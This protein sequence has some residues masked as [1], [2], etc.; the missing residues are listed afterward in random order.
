MNIITLNKFSLENLHRLIAT[1]I[2]LFTFVMYYYTVAPTVSFWDCGEYIACSYRMGI[3]HPPGAPLYLLIARIFTLIPM[4]KDI[5]LRVNMI[6]VISSSLTTVL[7]YLIIVHLYREIVG[8]L[9]S[10]NEWI[11]AIFSG[12]LGALTFAFTHSIW[13]NAVE[14]EVY[15]LSMFLMALMVWLILVWNAKSQEPGNERYLLFIAY[16]I[17]LSTGIHLLTILVLPFLALIFYF[18]RYNF[19]IQSFIIL[20]IVTTF[21]MLAIF[22]GL[23]VKVPQMAKLIGVFPIVFFFLVINGITIWAFISKKHLLTL[24]LFSILLISGGYSTYTY[25]IIRSSLNPKIDMNNPETLDK[26]ASYVNREQYG[27]HSII[28]RRAVWENSPNKNQ[29]RSPSDFFW[30]YQVNK[31]YIRYFLWQ[32]VGRSKN[33]IDWS[34]DQFFG[35]PLLLG[36]VGMWWHFRKSTTYALSVFTLFFITGLAI[37]LYLNQSEPQPRER[38]YSYIGSFFA[39]SIWI[40]L[41]FNALQNIL[42]PFFN[43]KN[44][45]YHT[46]FQS[47]LFSA[48]LM[49]APAQMLEK[50]IKNHSRRGNYF[51]WDFAYNTLMSC[52]PNGILFT[53]G[54][55]DTYPLWYLQEVEGIRTDVRVI[56][57]QLL[58]TGWHIR[59]LR[60]QSPRVPIHISDH[61]IENIGFIPWQRQQVMLNIPP[62]IVKSARTEYMNEYQLSQLGTPDHIIFQIEPTYQTSQGPLLGPMK[63]LILNI[64][65]TN[66]WERPIHFAVTMHH[67]EVINDL[68]QYLRLDGLTY[69]LVPYRNWDISSVHLRRNLMGKFK[70]RNLNNSSVYYNMDN[71]NLFQHYRHAFIRLATFYSRKDN[72]VELKDTLHTMDRK[73]PESVIPYTNNLL[74]LYSETLK[75]V[76]G[77]YHADTYKIHEIEEKDIEIISRLLLFD[78]NKPKIAGQ[79]LEKLYTQDKI[80]PKLL[81]LLIQAYLM[82]DSEEKAVS[83]LKDWL[84]I[85]PDDRKAREIL[86]QIES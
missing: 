86:L 16:L 74:K 66:A 59:Q 14:A 7:L 62:K 10:T 37:V 52:E 44:R 4:V 32:F 72:I 58:Q 82:S 70:Y 50:N 26:F 81:S 27:D 49:A 8:S 75:I 33:G 51:A 64:I 25:I 34:F 35:L 83:P 47:L 45:Y 12:V 48:L 73:M 69:K 3:S 79:L 15:S 5:A 65:Y 42:K 67:D 41:G 53:N 6:S 1:L 21:L 39:F 71:I 11:T 57:L 24:I 77:I 29:Y 22:P 56:C 30:K 18:N 40:G 55:N 63:Q 23:V 85:N 61:E 28:N 68:T 84:K 19:S 17:G 76:A 60:D 20:I 80:K 54:D 13:F 78:L 9:K 38:D 43:P 31:M 46:L 2:G 36:L